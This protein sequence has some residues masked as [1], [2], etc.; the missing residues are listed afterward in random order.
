ML[1]HISRFPNLSHLEI[2]TPP[3]PDTDA[4]AIACAFLESDSPF[5][6]PPMSP[7]LNPVTPDLAEDI[8]QFI[9]RRKANYACLAGNDSW[10][11]FDCLEIIN[12]EWEPMIEGVPQAFWGLGSLTVFTCRRKIGVPREVDVSVT[13]T[14]GITLTEVHRYNQSLALTPVWD[15]RGVYTVNDSNGV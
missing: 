13:S 15:R 5:L 8:F 12:R 6:K 14:V 3:V 1:S 11:S 9:A 2:N 10:R 4:L 7:I